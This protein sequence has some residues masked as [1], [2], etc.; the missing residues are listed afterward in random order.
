MKRNNSGR[1]IFG[2]ACLLIA[3]A[4]VLQ[5]SNLIQIDFINQIGVVKFTFTV[6]LGLCA[7]WS[8]IKLRIIQLLVFATPL[9]CMYKEELG[10]NLS[11]GII[12]VVAMLVIVAVSCILPDSLKQGRRHNEFSGNVEGGMHKN[13]FRHGNSRVEPEVINVGDEETVD[14]TG[15]F[16]GA[17]KYV[18]STN[19]KRV[20]ISGN[21]AGFEVYL[22]KAQLKDNVLEVYVDASFAGINL[23]VPY[24]W[25]VVNEIDHFMGGVDDKNGGQAYNG[26][27]QITM[28]L[29][30]KL[31]LSGVE[32]YRV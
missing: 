23:Y 18:D 2:I 21:F 27:S 3:A 29:K 6:V 17:V 11:I 22:N 28:V 14:I 1:I 30:G 26:G 25:R 13:D 5:Q 8:L 31:S 7:V 32:I 12:I 9:V 10:I 15:S 19:L 20:N 16:S 4:I 24:D